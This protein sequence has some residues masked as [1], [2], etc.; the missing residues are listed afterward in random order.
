MKSSKTH[1]RKPGFEVHELP[2]YHKA[3]FAAL[4]FP[5]KA[6]FIRTT[7]QVVGWIKFKMF[8]QTW[9]KQ[10]IHRVTVTMSNDRENACQSFICYCLSRQKKKEKKDKKK[11]EIDRPPPQKKKIMVI[12]VCWHMPCIYMSLCNTIMLTYHLYIMSTYNILHCRYVYMLHVSYI[13]YGYACRYN[14][15]AC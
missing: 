4:S 15:H 11:K 13:L 1:H 10:T 8:K 6:S 14:L 2:R 12:L 7:K 3:K 9:L 5:I